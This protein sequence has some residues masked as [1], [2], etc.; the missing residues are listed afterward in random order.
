M[1]QYKSILPE[2][3]PFNLDIN[4]TKKLEFRKKRSQT[5]IEN[6]VKTEVLSNLSN[7]SKISNLSNIQNSPRFELKIGQNVQI[8]EKG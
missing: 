8:E 5:K 3:D 1:S 6:I 7:L 4:K 2:I